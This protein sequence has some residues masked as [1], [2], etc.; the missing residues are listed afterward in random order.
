MISSV[1][2]GGVKVASIEDMRVDQDG[3]VVVTRGILGRPMK[4]GRQI[5]YHF[6][7]HT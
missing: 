2:L 4:F 3:R 6:S 1:L 5:D 7:Y